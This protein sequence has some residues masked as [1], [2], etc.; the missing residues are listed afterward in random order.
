[1]D[2]K[3]FAQP[4]IP[5]GASAHTIM[6]TIQILSILKEA[7]GEQFARTDAV[8]KWKEA[9]AP[10]THPGL[11]NMVSVLEPYLTKLIQELP[12]Y[13]G[14]ISYDRYET[15]NAATLR[16]EAQRTQHESHNKREAGYNYSKETLAH[17]VIFSNTS[18]LIIEF[19]G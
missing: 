11:A 7:L 19:Q 9:P 5:P 1:M 3:S 14:S 6:Y 18:S 17:I 10:N 16:Q 2:A 8:R 15:V 4:F 12:V 13:D